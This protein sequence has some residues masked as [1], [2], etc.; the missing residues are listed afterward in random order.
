MDSWYKKPVLNP[1]KPKVEPWLISAIVFLA[2]LT[3]TT[4]LWYEAKKNHTEDLNAA[5]NHVADQTQNNIRARLLAYETVMRGVKGFIDGSDLVTVTEFRSY[6]DALKLKEK[7]FGVLGIGLVTIV[8]G[9]DKVRHLEDIRKLGLSNYQIRPHGD[10]QSYA[11]IIRMEPMAGDNLKA[12]GLDLLSVPFARAAMERARDLNDVVVSNHFS[13]AQDQGKANVFSFVM[14]LPVFKSGANLDTLNARRK[15]ITGWVDVPFRIKDLMAGLNGEF[16]QDVGL[17]IHD[18]KAISDHSLIYSSSSVSTK[19]TADTRLKTKRQLDFAGHT[20]TLSLTITP[21]FE[22][23]VSNLNQSRIVAGAGVALS[24]LLALLSWVLVKGQQVAENRYLKLFKQSGFGILLLNREQH[25]L[26]A[27]PAALNMLGY[28]REELLN[29][30]LTRI[31]LDKEQ[32]RINPV[33]ESL[34]AGESHTDEWAHVRKDG[35]TFIA[36]VNARQLDNQTYFAILHDLTNRKVNEQRIVRLKNLYEALSE[37]NQAI[38]RMSDENE[39]FPL[40]C[41]CAVKFGGMKMAW[42]GVLDEPTQLILPVSTYGAGL[43]FL[44]SLHISVRADIQEGQ[45]PSGIAFRENHYVVVNNFLEDP[46][47]KPWRAS[48]QN[49]GWQ[50]LGAFPIARNGKPFAIF[51]VCSPE[52]NA[53]DQETIA[54]LNEMTSDVSFALDNFDRE[55]QR[56]LAQDKLQIAQLEATESRDRYQ[57]LYE[58]APIGYL[59]INRHGEINEVNWKVTSLVGLKRGEL[60]EQHFSQFVVDEDKARWQN[61]FLSMQEIDAGEELNFDIKMKHVSGTVITANLNCLRMD[62]ELD[63]PLIR[64]AMFDVTQLKHTEDERQRSDIRLQAT[65]DAIP[66]LLFEIDIHGRYFSAH[67]PSASLLPIPPEELIGKTVREVMPERAANIVMSAIKEADDLDRSQGMQFEL[68]LPGGKFWFELS[69]AKKPKAPGEDIR[70]ILLSRDVTERKQFEL[71]LLES[72]AGLA[73]AQASAHLG[74]WEL[75]L[76][77]SVGTWSDE[78]FRLYNL[79]PQLGTPTF[80]E[81]LELIHPDDRQSILDIQG[82]LSTLVGTINFESRT[83]PALGSVRTLSN[84]VQVIRNEHDRVLRATGTTLDITERKLAELEYRIAATAFESQEG[85]MV[86]DAKKNI[87]RVNK[88][89]TKISG[90]M[91]EEVVGQAPRLLSSAHHHEDFYDSMWQNIESTGYWE[92]EVWNRRKNGE[93]YPQHLTITAV[94]ADNGVVT[95]YVATF[96]DVTLRNAAEAE[97][98]N[99]AFYDVLTRLPNRRLLI[100]R[101]NH[102]LAT[103]ARLGWG[104]AL[105]FLDLDH[106]K[107]LNDTLGHD[108]GD[109]LLRQVAD[110]LSECVRE[111]D[112]VARLGGDEF[113]VMLED[114]SNHPLEAASQAEAIAHKILLSISQPYQLGLSSYQTSASIGVVLFSENEHAQDVLLKH[115]DIAMYQAKKMGRNTLCF[116][117][118]NMQEAINLRAQLEVDLRKAL[119]EKRFELY[120]QVQV[121][122]LGKAIGAEALIR[123]IHPDRGL[124]SPLEFIPLAE[125]TGLILPIGQWVLETACAQLKAWQTTTQTQSLTLS[126]NVS[127]KQ[128]YQSTFANQ[129][130]DAVKLSGINPM[131]LKLELTESIMLENIEATITKMKE[132]KNIGIN[133]SLDD[134]GTGYSSLQYLKSLP[135]YQLKI[136][137]SFVREIAFDTSDQAI[138][139]TVIAIAETLNLNVIAEGVETEE[140][141]QILMNCGCNAYQ[142]FLFGRPVPIGQFNLALKS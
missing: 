109:L 16:D 69:V 108:V 70:F 106:F 47:T 80:T 53:F 125:E 65:I 57:D 81:Y 99:L 36:E 140:Q 112:T 105:L 22:A 4:A 11:P 103:S 77:S 3:I 139:R 133:F 71:Q 31:L 120:Y 110:R 40:V 25:I 64:V 86:N 128:F 42:V 33:L 67:S 37:T 137:R 62:D 126:I 18:G 121:N 93:V 66:D 15:N 10:R 72:S 20:W 75:D 24:L 97:I 113:V 138:V 96:T 78:N 28:T 79:D 134:F 129:V 17:E 8:P 13:L 102:A 89:F 51:I 1:I 63:K 12:L 55:A 45:G 83:N 90:F 52:N 84:S 127:A 23:R 58:F 38:V 26:E 135:L 41:K 130:K 46:L 115:A 141:R 88:A 14:Y 119:D 54:L 60:N 34:M 82:Q 98:N 142:G 136:D 95:N 91:F 6:I 132:L 39:L 7:K 5:L 92:G 27:N 76:I 87:L 59:S 19:K 73:K 117:D 124:I 118:P 32:I 85:M 123:W 61:F 68:A 29:F 114:L 116:F 44:E 74:S 30:N 100:D 35:T 122:D 48:G 21:E 111:S 101:L 9:K 94:K 43:E 2:G 107:T 104:G 56:R 131:Q 49:Y 50:A